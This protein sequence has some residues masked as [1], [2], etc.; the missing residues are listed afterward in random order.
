MTEHPKRGKLKECLNRHL[1]N[2]SP[3]VASEEE[4]RGIDI[5][6]GTVVGKGR[7]KMLFPLKNLELYMH[8]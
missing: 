1:M 7:P 6:P 3:D 5:L 2:K 4:I 8:V